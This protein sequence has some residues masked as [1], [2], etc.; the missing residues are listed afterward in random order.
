MHNLIYINNELAGPTQSGDAFSLEI[1]TWAGAQA[2]MIAHP[3]R[4]RTA[5]Q[6]LLPQPC[7]R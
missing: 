7:T 5:D 3:T 4:Y 1:K 6:L 2:Q